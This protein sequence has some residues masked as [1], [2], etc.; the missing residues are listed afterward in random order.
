MENSEQNKRKSALGQEG[1]NI[2]R[3]FLEKKGYY[4]VE[5][6]YR[7]G[8]GEIDIIA[9]KNETLIFIEVKTK[10]YGD[11]GDPLEWINRKKQKQ[12]GTVAKGYLYEKDIENVDCQF[13]VI[14]LEYENGAYK[15]NHIED[16]FWL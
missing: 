15:I 1:E 14:A 9:R 13:D 5:T 11:F 16:A 3:D 12:L 8:R 10:K 7:F 6:N 2:A 4:I